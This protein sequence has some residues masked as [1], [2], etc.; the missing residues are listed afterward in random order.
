MEDSFDKFI[1]ILSTI[2]IDDVQDLNLLKRKVE[3]YLSKIKKDKRR[4]LVYVCTE[5]IEKVEVKK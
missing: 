2:Y 5:P 1:F 4:L 3:Y